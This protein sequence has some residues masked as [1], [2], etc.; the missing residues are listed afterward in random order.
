MHAQPLT[1]GER[2]QLAF[3]EARVSHNLEAFWLVAASLLAIKDRK[4]Y[5]E[6]FD[7]FEDYC[8]DRWHFSARYARYII[9]AKSIMDAL[10]ADNLPAPT[11]ESQLRPLQG[12]S[13]LDAKSIWSNATAMTSKPTAAQVQ[14]S[15]D[16]YLVT[17]SSYR[18][19]KDALDS[20]TITPSR[21]RQAVVALNSCEAG[22]RDTIAFRLQV[23]DPSVILELNR[24]YRGGSD[25]YDEILSSGYLQFEDGTGVAIGRATPSD[26]RRK[27]DQE[28]ENHVREELIARGSVLVQIRKGDPNKTFE[29]LKKYLDRDDLEGLYDAL[30]HWRMDNAMS[31][32]RESI[33]DYS[34]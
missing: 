13:D 23:N 20:K 14:Q 2:E 4:L 5:R 9:R 18:P 11:H 10:L 15:A 28:R 6:S 19:I 30:F 22:C 24:L 3:H 27:L 26:L 16:E 34:K 21:A 17:Q 31:K 8:E 25:V 33:E 12:L 29:E 32:A 7:T 1:D